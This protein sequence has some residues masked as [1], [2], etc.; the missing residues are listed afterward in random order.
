MKIAVCFSG[1][2]SGF[3]KGK[4]HAIDSVKHSETY[5]EYL[6]KNHDVDTFMHSWSVGMEGKLTE[7]Y[8]PKD[9][10][11]EKQIIF[12][13]DYKISDGNFLEKKN[14]NLKADKKTGVKP[15]QHIL[16]SQMYSR[17]KSLELMEAYSKKFNVKYD[18][19]MTIRYDIVFAQPIFLEDLTQDCIYYSGWDQK[20]KIYDLFFI[21][22]EKYIE[23][24][25]QLYDY[26]KDNL[27]YNSHALYSIMFKNLKLEPV[28]M[29]AREFALVRPGDP[30]HVLGRNR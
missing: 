2:A 27:V 21:F 8:S 6:F 14:Y 20:G 15:A 29:V 5:K 9:K 26:T 13:D 25:K 3:G 12:H 11:F 23:N 16:R 10:L 19:V 24:I 30:Y 18:L 28:G 4:Q 22:K 7:I 17:K 1:L